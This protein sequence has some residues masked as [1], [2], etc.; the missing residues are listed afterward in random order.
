MADNLIIDVTG[1]N[2]NKN[3]NLIVYPNPTTGRFIIATNNGSNIELFNVFGQEV[4]FKSTAFQ[5]KVQ[6]DITNQSNGVYFIKIDSS[7]VRVVK[8]N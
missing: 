1:I 8:Q 2:E 3:E 4:E 5:N 7:V 6:I